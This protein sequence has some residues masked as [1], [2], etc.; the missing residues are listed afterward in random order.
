M[1]NFLSLLL[2]WASYRARVTLTTP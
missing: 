2:C 1:P